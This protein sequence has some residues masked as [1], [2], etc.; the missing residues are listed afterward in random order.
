MVNS[1]PFARRLRFPMGVDR[2]A[3][4][5]AEVSDYDAYIRQLIRQV[6]LTARGERIN[7]PAFGAGVRRLVF[8]PLSDASAMLAKTMIYEALS[9]W[10]SGLIAVESVEAEAQESRLQIIVCYRVIAHGERR[11][12]NEEVVLR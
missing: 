8:A 1:D 5:L 3:G 10:L 2:P 9:R 4:R 7:R 11:Y 12:L 6:L